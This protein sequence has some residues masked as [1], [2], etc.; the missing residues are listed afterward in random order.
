MEGGGVLLSFKCI[1]LLPPLPPSLSQV[2]QD[3]P[4]AE[5]PRGGSTR[6]IKLPEPAGE[7]VE[8]ISPASD[9]C[10]SPYSSRLDMQCI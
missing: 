7:G 4:S 3:L 1:V 10:V 8:I 9:E 2:F 5:P 6:T